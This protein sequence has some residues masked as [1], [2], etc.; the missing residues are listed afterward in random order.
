MKVYPNTKVVENRKQIT[1]WALKKPKP[2]QNK[3][4][5]HKCVGKI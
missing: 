4:K 1:N 3:T 5:I 2:K